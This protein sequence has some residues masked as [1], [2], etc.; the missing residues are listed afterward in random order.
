MWFLHQVIL[1]DNFFTRFFLKIL[2]KTV[3]LF[4]EP[5]Q[6]ETGEKERE[7]GLKKENE[8]LFQCGNIFDFFSFNF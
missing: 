1:K 8:L 2:R 7:K 5:S 3:S 4:E 6:V